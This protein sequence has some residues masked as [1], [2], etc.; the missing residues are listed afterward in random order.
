MSSNIQ[1]Q[2]ICKYCG[3]EFT[4]RTTTTLYCS[5]KCNSKDYKAKQRTTKVEASN[6]ETEKTKA[7]PFES[8]KAKE[9][10]TVPEVAKLLNCSTRTAYRLITQGNIKGV[11]LG[12][13]LTRVK[14]SELDKILN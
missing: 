13:R 9:I 14:R 4:A 8:L 12:Q 2:R 3:N 5:H 7:I 1:L 10:L 6:N 11:N